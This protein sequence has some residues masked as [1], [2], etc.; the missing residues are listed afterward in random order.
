MTHTLR[1]DWTGNSGKS[2]ID[3]ISFCVRESGVA[4]ISVSASDSG[5]IISGGMRNC[6]E[7]MLSR[8]QARGLY[9]KCLN[10]G[11]KVVDQVPD[12]NY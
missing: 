1:L 11:Y 6:T 10:E 5:K 2:Y 12:L 9:K 4:I 7:K 8:Q 3:M